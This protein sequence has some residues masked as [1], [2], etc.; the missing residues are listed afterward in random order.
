MP[1]APRP[2]PPPKGR[3][4]WWVELPEQKLLDVRLCDLRVSLE[5]SPLARSVA[6]LHAEF[7][8]AGLRFRP[9]VWLSTDWFTPDGITGFG[10]P[11]FLAHPRL[12][13]LERNQMFEAEGSTRDWC[14]KLLRHES[15]HAV[16]N[17]YRLRRRKDWRE[18]FGRASEP[19]R[20][21]YVPDPESRKYVQNLDNWYAQSHPVEDFA[22][23]FAAWLRPGNRWRRRYAGWPVALRK[24]HYV[25]RLMNEL[26]DRAPPVRTRERPDSLAKLRFSLRE[27]YRRKQ[28][29][30]GDVDHTVYDRD[31]RR[32]FTEE[33]LPG[34]RRASSFLRDRRP[35]LRERVAH[36]TGQQAF[37][38]DEVL[39][40]MILRARALGLR[41]DQPEREAVQDAS[42]VLTVHTM[43]H[44]RRR[45]REY[46]R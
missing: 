43:R 12:A 16:D 5:E 13:R 23:T 20:W 35:E 42:V 40:G 9:Y 31:L 14:M 34:R 44:L 11:F 46:F 41:L 1:Q 21:S 17:A 19:Y 15:A 3:G 39:K 22:E 26:A 29:L 8:R 24:L 33:R 27:Y 7:E 25:D 30:Y 2:P 18:H 4:P 10:V 6:Q 28:A 36:W 38:V 32:L 37:V 45:H